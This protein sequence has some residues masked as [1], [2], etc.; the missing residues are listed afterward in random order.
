MQFETVGTWPKSL[1]GV[2][3]WLQTWP[4]AVV[5]VPAH[6]IGPTCVISA[7]GGA[8][9]GYVSIGFMPNQDFDS[10]VTP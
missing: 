4:P 8:R 9:E 10:N 3:T 2:A 1:R 6:N 7:R 5:C